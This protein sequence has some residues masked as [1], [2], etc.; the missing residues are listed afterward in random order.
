MRPC[1]LI[2]TLTLLLSAIVLARFPTSVLVARE[3]QLF[4]RG[5]WENDTAI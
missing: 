2:F 1:T 4:R 5:P 3:P